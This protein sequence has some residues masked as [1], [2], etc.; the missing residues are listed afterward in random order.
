MFLTR[1]FKTFVV[2]INTM[3]SQYFTRSWSQ[4]YQT[5]FL[6]LRSIFLFSADKLGHFMVNGFEKKNSIIQIP[7]QDYLS[8][9][10]N[11]RAFANI[12]GHSRAFTG[13]CRHFKAFTI[14]CMVVCCCH[15]TGL[16]PVLLLY[17]HDVSK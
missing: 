14:I 7:I 8:E 9:L 17:L 2:N 11:S 5:F 1:I 13:I 10:K 15:E 12:R 16:K 6:R 3:N 4:S